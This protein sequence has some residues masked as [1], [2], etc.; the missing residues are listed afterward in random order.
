MTP[1][2]E[3]LQQAKKSITH[4]GI[5]LVIS[6]G[7]I[8]ASEIQSILKPFAAIENAIAREIRKLSKAGGIAK[9][10]TLTG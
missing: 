9:Q 4:L 7:E 1:T 5:E 10:N 8:D 2:I 3:K 6:R